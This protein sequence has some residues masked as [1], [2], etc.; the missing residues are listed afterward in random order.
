MTELEQLEEK[1]FGVVRG[2]NLRATVIGLFNLSGVDR[3]DF[4]RWSQLK[5]DA[6][7]DEFLPQLDWPWWLPASK[8]IPWLREEAEKRVPVLIDK[9]FDSVP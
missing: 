7:L 1:I 6:L 9:Y 3:A 4:K 8:V 5:V 2:R